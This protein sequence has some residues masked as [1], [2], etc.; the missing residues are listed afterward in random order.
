MSLIVISKIKNL[1]F[2]SLLTVALIYAALSLTAQPVA[3]VTTCNCEQLRSHATI[4]VPSIHVT[5]CLLSRRA[6]AWKDR[7]P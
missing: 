1:L 7:E 2:F 3:A 5:P 6:I 4:S